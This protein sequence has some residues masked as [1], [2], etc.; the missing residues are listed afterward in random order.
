MSILTKGAAVKYNAATDNEV[1]YYI[2]SLFGV[3]LIVCALTM[4]ILAT[5]MKW[6]KSS[7]FAK[8]CAILAIIIIILQ[9]I[10]FSP[11]GCGIG[12]IAG[13]A[14]TLLKKENQPKHTKQVEKAETNNGVKIKKSSLI[15]LKITAIIVTLL[16]IILILLSM[17]LQY[18]PLGYRTLFIDSITHTYK[19]NTSF[20]YERYEF[21]ISVREQ[22]NTPFQF[23]C[24]GL[25]T[26]GIF[27][28]DAD[29]V[30]DPDTQNWWPKEACEETN[31]EKKEEAT[32]KKYLL[33]K[34]SI[35]NKSGDLSTIPSNWLTVIDSEGNQQYES[36]DSITIA[37]NA[38]ASKELKKLVKNIDVVSISIALPG[39][40][41]Q[42]V[43]VSQD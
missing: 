16:F 5:I 7:Y 9:T 28:P 34:Y 30:A 19:E 31:L 20:Q 10:S 22:E 2:G 17:L 11:L 26:G 12:I 41:P 42:I 37:P 18:S 3:A 15:V 23:D 29:N 8:V 14:T 1:A 40:S 25:V 38:T 39:H 43:D 32:S 27:G 33:I 21:K 4:F 24:S 6:K 35:K 36:S 13:I